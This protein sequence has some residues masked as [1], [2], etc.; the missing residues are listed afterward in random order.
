MDVRSEVYNALADIVFQTGAAKDN[1]EDAI[2][3]FWK[4]FWVEEEE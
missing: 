4:K 1:M 3:F 2:A